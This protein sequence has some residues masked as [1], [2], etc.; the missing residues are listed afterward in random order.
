MSPRRRWRV[1]DCGGKRS[2]TPL[3]AA[4]GGLIV[5]SSSP[6]RKR[7]RRSRSAGA[8]HDAPASFEPGIDYGVTNPA[9][10]G[11][12]LP[13]R[14]WRTATIPADRPHTHHADERGA[15]A[16]RVYPNRALAVGPTCATARR[17]FVGSLRGGAQ[18]CGGR[19]RPPPHA[20]ARALPIARWRHVTVR[21]QPQ[22][23]RRRRQTVP[24]NSSTLNGLRPFR[25]H[26]IQPRTTRTTRN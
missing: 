26:P 13:S 6:A 3:S 23:P 18:R 22:R 2:A 4:R 14:C 25:R 10:A 5:Q 24:T 17:S 19:G 7:R 8:L 12:A 11:R 9:I 1:L 16:P 15:H 20:R 21:D